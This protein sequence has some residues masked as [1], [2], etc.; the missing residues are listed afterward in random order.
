MDNAPTSGGAAPLVVIRADPF[1]AETQL[2]EHDGIVTPTEAFYVRN[3]F[4]IP[5]LDSS[6]WLLRLDGAVDRVTTWNYEQLL[7]LP[8]RNLLVTLECAGNGRSGMTP[9]PPGELWRYGAV[10]TAEWTGV[11]L[12]DLLYQAGLSADAVEIVAE[13]ADNG[14]VEDVGNT[15]FFARSLPLSQALHKDI[16]VAYAMNGEP[17]TPEHGFPVRLVVPGWYGVASV[18][19]LARLCVVTEPFCGFFQKERYQLV[20]TPSSASA[21]EPQPVPLTTMAIRS[22]LIRPTPGAILQPGQHRVQGL[23]WSGAIPVVRVEVSSDG[24]MYW[25]HAHLLGEPLPYAWRQ[26]EY[27]WHATSPGHAHL[28]SRAV[29]AEGNS[30]PV[31]IAWNKLGYA[32]N[33]IQRVQ[34]EIR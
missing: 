15:M 25:E 21:G 6:E 31:E 32:N 18:K 9:R 30:Q 10:S 28:C 26:W 13:G 2:H 23:A 33:A 3:H 22:L 19:W 27:N 24:G 5:R 4:S 7:S 20:Y 16:L 14:F 17:L 11:P 29:D 1:N 12:A 8:S 34:V